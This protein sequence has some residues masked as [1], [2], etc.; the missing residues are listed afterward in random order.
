MCRSSPFGQ[1]G[2]RDAF[3]PT[4]SLRIPTPSQQQHIHI[5]HTHQNVLCCSWPF[6]SVG[7]IKSTKSSVALRQHDAFTTF[8]KR[9]FADEK[10]DFRVDHTGHRNVIVTTIASIET[11]THKSG[12]CLCIDTIATALK[13]RFGAFRSASA[14]SLWLSVTNSTL[15]DMTSIMCVHDDF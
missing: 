12:R 1:F 5:I 9:E 13:S 3:T 14:S 7:L 10:G 8:E 6:N 2:T 4:V 11:R 15:C